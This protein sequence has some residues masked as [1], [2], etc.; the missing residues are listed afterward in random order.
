[1]EKRMDFLKINSIRFYIN[2]YCL[3]IKNIYYC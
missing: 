1:M 3:N 2:D